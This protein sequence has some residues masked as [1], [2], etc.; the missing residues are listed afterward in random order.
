MELL[1]FSLLALVGGIILNFMPCVLPVLTMK[2]FHVVET[3]QESPQENRR[4]G[5]ASANSDPSDF[6][7]LLSSVHTP[8]VDLAWR[9]TFFRLALDV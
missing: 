6:I 9:T 4:L 7:P 3:A 1:E 2:V 8:S 5:T